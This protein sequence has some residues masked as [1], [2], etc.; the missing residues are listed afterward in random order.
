[1][2]YDQALEALKSGAVIHCGIVRHVKSGV[3]SLYYWM[4]PGGLPV[5]QKI[6]QTL[7][8]KKMIAP[9]ED[10]LFDQI[11]QQTWRLV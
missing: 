8:I 10:V 1:M 9:D 3:S 4:E 6:V 5:D 7:A 2:T 11:P